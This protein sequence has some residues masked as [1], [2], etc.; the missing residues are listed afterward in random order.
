MIIIRFARSYLKKQ[1]NKTKLSFI[2]SGI[3]E[4]SAA[5]LKQ[6]WKDFYWGPWKPIWTTTDIC[7][8]NLKIQPHE[9]NF[10]DSRTSFLNGH[11]Y[12]QTWAPPGQNGPMAFLRFLVRTLIQGMDLH[13]RFHRWRVPG[14]LNKEIWNRMSN[15]ANLTNSSPMRRQYCLWTISTS[16]GAVR[17]QQECRRH[18]DHFQRYLQCTCHGWLKTVSTTINGYPLKRFIFHPTTVFSAGKRLEHIGTSTDL[19]PISF[20]CTGIIGR[21]QLLY[22]AQ[23][24]WGHA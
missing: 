4:E 21:R 13:R 6:G 2:Q 24:L 9:T 1:E 5:S 22:R 11:C 7:S 23:V 18:L 19:H 3:P 14:K 17:L 16:Y 20:H 10:T 15:M 8:I 12:G